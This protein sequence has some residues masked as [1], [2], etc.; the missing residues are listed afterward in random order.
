M[1]DREIELYETIGKLHKENYKLLDEIFEIL[2]E[3][4]KQLAYM[5]GLREKLRASNFKEQE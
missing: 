5:Q 1:T 2:P 4:H 3:L